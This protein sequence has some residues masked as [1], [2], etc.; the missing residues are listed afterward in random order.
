[1]LLEKL[2]SINRIPRYFPYLE[3]RYM[4]TTIFFKEGNTLHWSITTKDNKDHVMIFSACFPVFNLKSLQRKHIFHMFSQ[5]IR[6]CMHPKSLQLCPALCDPVDCG[7][8]GSS[9]H[10]ILQARIL[11]WIAIPSSRDFTDPGIQSSYV[12]CVGRQVLYH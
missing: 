6:I 7:P 12:S 1:M 3:K 2:L 4:F 5:R 11:V 10:G 9:L 8:L